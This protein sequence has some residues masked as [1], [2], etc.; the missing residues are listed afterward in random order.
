MSVKITM[1]AAKY[2]P[3]GQR[4]FDSVRYD[5]MLMRIPQERGK[6]RHDMS[7]MERK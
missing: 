3:R 7:R 1:T 2:T 4:M 5:V 6:S